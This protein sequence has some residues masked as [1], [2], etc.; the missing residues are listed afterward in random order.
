MNAT[1]SFLRLAL[2]GLF[3]ASFFHQ[4][5]WAQ[6]AS[7]RTARSLADRSF[8]L[9]TWQQW[10]SVLLLEDYN[11]RVVVLSVAM[12]GIAA[13]LIG[14]FTLL[15]RRALI[16]DALA[17][18]SFPGIAVAFMVVTALGASGKSLP[19]LLTGATLGGLAGVGLILFVQKYTRLKQDAA[20]GIVLSVFFGFGAALLGVIQQMKTGSAAGLET[21]VYGKTASIKYEDAVLIACVAIVAILVCVAFFKELK[22]LCF[23][24][25]FAESSGM[26]TLLFDIVLMAMVVAVTMIGLQAVGLILMVALL[27]I[28]PAAARFWTDSLFR[29][30]IVSCVF[31]LL[32]GVVGAASSALLPKLPSGAMIVLVCAVIFMISMAWGT[33]RGVIPRFFRRMQLNRAIDRQ[34]LLRGLFELL[35]KSSAQTPTSNSIEPIA[36]DKL[37]KLRSWSARRLS[38]TIQRS[39]AEGLVR[40]ADEGVRLTQAGFAEAARLT[41]QHRLWELFLIHHA[42]IAPSRVDR[43]ADDIEHVLEPEIVDELERLLDQPP[44]HFDVPRDPHRLKAQV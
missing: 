29:L 3:L 11:T 12:L 24:Q 23:D 21:F 2:A 39:V 5:T 37:R 33:S 32:G 26:S 16:G 28:P 10:K 22:L 40:V 1:R 38:K 36:I 27:V 34:H 7:T 43:D 13:G 8:T 19:V 6:S 4:T 35:E 17:H 15:R 30:T 31:G 14:S 41:R 20:L 42:D 9:P 18:A 25:Q 44:V